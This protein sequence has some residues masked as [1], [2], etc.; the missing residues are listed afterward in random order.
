MHFVSWSYTGTENAAVEECRLPYPQ[1]GISV[2]HVSNSAHRHLHKGCSF[3]R[4]SWSGERLVRRNMEEEETLFKCHS[5]GRMFVLEECLADHM[6]SM[7][8]VYDSTIKA[9]Q[10]RTRLYP[11]HIQL[12]EH[13]KSGAMGRRL[14]FCRWFDAHSHLHNSILFDKKQYTCTGRNSTGNSHLWSRT[15]AYSKQNKQTPWP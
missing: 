5:A 6:S 7:S 10:G 15:F 8:R 11:C 1:K 3:P 12:T 4:A 9:A 2:R 14:E 13:L